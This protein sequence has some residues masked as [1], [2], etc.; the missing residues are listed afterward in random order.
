MTIF[1]RIVVV[2]KS[3][4]PKSSIEVPDVLLGVSVLSLTIEYPQ[5]LS[6]VESLATYTPKLIVIKTLLDAKT[7]VI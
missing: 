6:I 2:E 7:S 4:F 3:Q 5:A 1:N